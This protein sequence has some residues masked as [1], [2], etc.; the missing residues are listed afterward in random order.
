MNTQI[1]KQKILARLAG[2]TKSYGKH[3]VL[4]PID[5]EIRAGEKV[6]IIGPSGAGKTTLLKVIAGEV[7]QS[8]G[9]VEID[10]KPVNSISHRQR[11]RYVGLM[12]QQFDLVP[13]L[14]ARR[15][16]EVGNSGRWSLLRTLAG[17]LLPVHDIRSAEI[18]TQLAI[19]ELLDERTA[20]LSGGQQQRV[21]LARLMVQSPDLL[22]ADEPVSSL[23][24]KLAAKSL[25]LLCEE[26]GATNGSQRAI[27]ANLHTPSLAIRFFDRVVGLSDGHI[28]FDKSSESV[29]EYDLSSMYGDSDTGP[30][31]PS[32]V[33]DAPTNW[34]RD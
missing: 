26:L 8:R 5:L 10:Y 32:D 11:S 34:G 24:P 25:Q 3:L 4:G 1:G 16:I 22:L 28:S 19:T 29:T 7:D 20:R 6:A 14:S 27:I 18:A 13:Q 31:L 2:V 15:N 30:E 23:D 12:H 33:T 9:T 17:L 21:A